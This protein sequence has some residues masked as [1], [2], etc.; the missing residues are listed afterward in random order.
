MTAA[1]AYTQLL[2]SI[3]RILG[4][5]GFARTKQSFRIESNGNVGI[6]AVQKSLKSTADR[7]VFTL[8][9]GVWSSRIAGFAGGSSQPTEIDDCHWR[10]RIGFLLPDREDTWWT[11][12][13]TDEPAT[14]SDELRPVIEDVVVPAVMAHITD[15]AL[16]DEWLTGK[17]PGLTEVQRLMHLAVLLKQIGPQNALSSV[18]AELESKSEGKPAEAIVARHLQKL[19]LND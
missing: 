2:K 7:V 9:V 5:A 19:G 10:E 14:V 13:E 16:R 4:R 1:S 3:E 11:I 18:V 8:N 12:R 15:E 17:S 6:I